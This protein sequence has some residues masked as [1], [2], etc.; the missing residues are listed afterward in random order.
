MWKLLRQQLYMSNHTVL[1][2]HSVMG[3]C[4]VFV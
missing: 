2:Y 4:T 1:R 3:R